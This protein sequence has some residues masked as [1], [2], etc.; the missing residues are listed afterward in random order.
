M[1]ANRLIDYGGPYMKR[2][3]QSGQSLVETALILPVLLLLLLGVWDFGRAIYG[4]ITISNAARDGARVA[5]VDQRLGASGQP[6][7][8]EA[9]ANQATSLGLSPDSDVDVTYLEDPGG[10]ACTPVAVGCIAR[11]DV[12]YSYRAITPIISSIV[13][14]LNLSSRTELPVENT[15]VLP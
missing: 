6:L 13:G 12:R 4:Y 7:A 9:A 5:I 10:P 2:T 15:R 11:V 3:S 1:S 8:A 14:S